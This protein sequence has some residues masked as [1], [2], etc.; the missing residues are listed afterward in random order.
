LVG[1]GVIAIVAILAAG[2][3]VLPAAAWGFVRLLTGILSAS[4]WFASVLG[5]GEDSW[6]IASSV[7]S[8]GT[9]LFVTPRVSG[10]LALLVLLGAASLF[11]LQRLLGTEEEKK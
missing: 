4:I 6:T 10:I 11:G 3:I 1:I 9:Q 5:S 7:V 2:Y 8:A